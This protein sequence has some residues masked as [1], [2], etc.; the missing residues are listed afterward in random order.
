MATVGQQSS[1]VGKQILSMSNGNSKFEQL[2]RQFEQT[3]NEFHSTNNNL[4]QVMRVHT[5]C[6]NAYNKA[7]QQRKTEI[8]QTLRHLRTV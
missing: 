2:V 7:E 6:I 8:T 1:A 5:P 3:A 4:Q